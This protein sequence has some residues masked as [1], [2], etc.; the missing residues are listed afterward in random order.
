[1]S[2]F[3]FHQQ[4]WFKL[5][6]LKV[7]L[8]YSDFCLLHVS[9][10][11]FLRTCPLSP[12]YILSTASVRVPL[13]NVIIYTL[14][15]NSFV[16]LCR[17]F[18]SPG[19]TPIVFCSSYQLSLRLHHSLTLPLLASSLQLSNFTLTCL[20]SPALWLDPYSPRLSRSLTLPL[21]ASSLQLSDFTLIC[22][23][24]PALWLYPYLHCLSSSLTLPIFAYLSHCLTLNSSI[25]LLSP[26]L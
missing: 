16:N 10:F 21:F 8:H 19:E 5:L 9:W 12:Q 23:V 7:S 2:S 3:N 1:M 18:L 14:K 13:N 4:K 25:C 17:H 20:V 11:Q 24:S 22:L 15:S 26:T 6:L